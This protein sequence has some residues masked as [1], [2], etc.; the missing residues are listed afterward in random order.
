MFRKT[1]TSPRL[2]MFSSSSNL[3]GKI[4]GSNMQKTTYFSFRGINSFFGS[5]SQESEFYP[6]NFECPFMGALFALLG[7]DQLFN[8][9][10]TTF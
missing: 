5:L 1:T 9:K 7:Q 8:S 10:N 3:L 4:P 6:G 2:D